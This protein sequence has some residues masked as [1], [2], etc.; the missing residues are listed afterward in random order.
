MFGKKLKE[1]RKQLSKTQ[2]G[3][4]TVEFVQNVIKDG[5]VDE[6]DTSAVKE[7]WNKVK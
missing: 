3:M 1:I 7:F 4:A 5:K 6:S 2:E